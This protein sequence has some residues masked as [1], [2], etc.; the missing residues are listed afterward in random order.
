MGDTELSCRALESESK[1]V[2]LIPCYNEE[3]TIERAVRDFKE[4]LPEAEIFVFDNNST[5][6]TAQVAK[7]TGATVVQS[8]RQGKGNVVRHMFDE[9]EADIYLMVDGDDTYPASAA[10]SLIEALEKS[11][12][13][14]V[15]G[16]RMKDF[17]Q[18]SFRRFHQFGN[19]LVA[20]LI[21]LLFKVKV[22]DVL[23]GYRAFSRQFVKTIP[24]ASQ[25]FE[26]ETEMTLQ[27]AAK[28]FEIKEVPVKYRQRPKGSYSKLNTYSDGFLI[29]KSIIM[30]FKDYKPLVF[31][32]AC[33]IILGILSI[34]FGIAPIQDFYTTGK[35][36]HLPRA[37]L[38]AAV[39][40]LATLSFAIGLIL[41]TI[42]KYHNE[43]FILWSRYLK[44]HG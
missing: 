22:T 12:A 23:S 1:V 29:I 39:G 35:V 20:K 44:K 16:C 15:V 5:D 33:S 36:E 2:V 4:N 26:I 32:T 14:M 27:A 9:I 25:G 38:A 10:T 13:E 3:A 43:N 6:K 11:R 30:I 8:H 34:F 21:S 18:H 31:F 7:Q 37:V 17:G 40:I 24:L 41:D 28:K 42:S 19:R